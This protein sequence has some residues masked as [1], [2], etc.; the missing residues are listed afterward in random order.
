MN[1]AKLVRKLR[2]EKKLS[3]GQADL[4]LD[5]QENRIFSIHRELRFFLYIGILMVIAG[6]GLTIKQ[7][8]TNLG[9]IAI[10]SA[11]TLCSVAAFT[12][13]FWK[14][15]AFAKNEVKSPGIAF[16]YILFFGCAFY[17][18]DIAYI[19]TQLHILGDG[20]KNYLLVSVV[21]FFFLSYRFDN[22][23]VLS[24]ALSTLATWFGFTLLEHR[25]LF[26]EYYRL[27]AMVY[28]LLVLFGGTLLYRLAVK[29]HFFDVYL[30]FA[31]HFLC[32]ALI[33]GVFEYK[34]FSLYFPGLLVACGALVF[35]AV[36]VRKFLY[37]L[38]AIIYGYIGLSIVII[39]QIQRQTFFVF[40]YFI[41]TSLL[42]IGL[43]FKI[44]RRF[45]EEK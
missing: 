8:F 4:L 41:L 34:I 35:Y 2:Y 11:L 36:R 22:R 1:I 15:N 7:Y 10:I 42:V 23:L 3:A 33:S 5:L 17:S 14:G 19:E 28:G 39:D 29:I 44:S 31:V 26:G 24:L 12:Y 32:I 40:A 27:C 45:R 18:M 20:W 37:M 9:N 13:C 6:A 16:D 43:I 25:F 21:V 30:N 38:Y